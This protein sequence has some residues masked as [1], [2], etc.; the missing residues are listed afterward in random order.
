MI[1]KQH[2]TRYALQ[3]RRRLVLSVQDVRRVEAA[4]AQHDRRVCRI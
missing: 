4:G 2:H 1:S 3:P